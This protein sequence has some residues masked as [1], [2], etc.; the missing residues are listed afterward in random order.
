VPRDRWPLIAL[1]GGLTLLGLAIIAAAYVLSGFYN[2]SAR[3]RHFD[4]TTFFLD[5]VRRQSVITHAFWLEAP[6]L[7]DPD[8]VQLG[9]AHFAGGCA[10]CHGAPGQEPD[11]LAEAMLPEPPRLPVS[12]I[13]WSAEQL[14]WI[15]REGQKYTGMP[16]WLA[17][18]REDEIWA[19]VAFLEKLPLMEP[20]NYAELASG[21]HAKS[22]QELEFGFGFGGDSAELANCVR[23]HGEADA[24]PPSELVPR[25]GGQQ[26]AYLERALREFAAGIRPSGIMQMVAASLSEASIKGLASYYANGVAAPVKGEAAE[27]TAQVAS[28]AQIYASGVPESDVPPCIACHGGETRA[29]FP[30][31]EGLSARYVREQ[32]HVW[33]QGLRDQSS[34]GA[35]MSV[36]AKR[37][38]D[39]QIADVAAYL[40]SAATASA[41]GGS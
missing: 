36:V 9:A 17:P 12:A 37:L 41:G 13:D 18:E 4:I 33:K 1:G 20:E 29:S 27:D 3:Q 40:Q 2:V 10:F 6:E 7:D 21:G 22:L 19:V 16:H 30:R 8:M 35:I 15:V 14:F 38:T 23:C 24:A 39:A 5:V 26:R 28:G 11:P 34:Y 32:L 31:I 25:L